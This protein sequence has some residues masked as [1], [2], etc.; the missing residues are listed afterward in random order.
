VAVAGAAAEIGEAF[1]FSAIDFLS[2]SR[3]TG[4][5]GPVGAD[6]DADVIIILV[7]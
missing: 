4:R 6:G 3:T 2:Q 1:R 5:P 7:R